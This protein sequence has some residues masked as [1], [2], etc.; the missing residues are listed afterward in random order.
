MRKVRSLLD[1]PRTSKD[2]ARGLK[3]S[4][5]PVRVRCGVAMTLI[6]RR[7]KAAIR[8]RAG[9]SGGVKVM[10]GGDPPG[11]RHADTDHQRCQEPGKY[12]QRM[13]IAELMQID[14]DQ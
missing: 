1:A 7:M 9:Q 10:P 13:G 8:P 2:G 4:T 6:P 14:K 11:D 3:P 12:F 5:L